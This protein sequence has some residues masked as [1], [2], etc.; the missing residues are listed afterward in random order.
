ML[1]QSPE[2]FESFGV[3]YIFVIE[4][5]AEI[6]MKAVIPIDFLEYNNDIYNGYRSK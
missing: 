4:Y 6:G 1:N 2:P 3:P 5:A